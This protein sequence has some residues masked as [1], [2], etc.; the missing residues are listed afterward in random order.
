MRGTGWDRHTVRDESKQGTEHAEMTHLHLTLTS[1]HRAPHRAGGGSFALDCI[2][3]REGSTVPESIHRTPP[4]L[5]RMD[6]VSLYCSS[7]A[8]ITAITAINQV[9][10]CGTSISLLLNRSLTILSLPFVHRAA[11]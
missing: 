6:V 3:W 11:R 4:R 5:T 8:A 1:P 10:I 2:G 9:M 7:V